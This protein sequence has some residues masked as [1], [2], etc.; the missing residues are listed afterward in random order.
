MSWD[1]LFLPYANNKGADQPALLRRLICAFVVRCLD[2]IIPLVSISE[3]SSF[4]L[5]SVAAQ[6][7]LSLTWPQTPKTG[8][9]VT[10]LILKKV[11][12]KNLLEISRY[13]IVYHGQNVKK[14]A[15]KINRLT[16]WSCLN[17]FGKQ[18]YC[19][20]TQLRRKNA[21]PCRKPKLWQLTERQ[22]GE[23]QE[24]LCTCEQELCSV[25]N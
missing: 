19:P 12:G 25:I 6:A 2:S 13:T 11:T 3:I 1:N 8:L 21:E 9:L 22:K 5:T 14:I 20:T 16:V 15:C 18:K 24:M 7:G 4:H 10:R 17:G 23:R